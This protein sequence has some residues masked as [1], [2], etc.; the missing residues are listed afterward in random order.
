M[1][2]HILFYDDTPRTH[3]VC[4]GLYMEMWRLY[5]KCARVDGF[6]WKMLYERWYKV[7]FPFNLNHTSSIHAFSCSYKCF[8]DAVFDGE[9]WWVKC[10]WYMIY[11]YVVLMSINVNRQWLVAKDTSSVFFYQNWE[12][13]QLN[14]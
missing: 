7:Y 2:I 9:R 8:F 5:S 14:V 6:Q 4:N 10:L 13:N 1:R 12:L 11:V 3:H